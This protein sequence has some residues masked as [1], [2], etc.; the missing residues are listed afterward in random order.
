MRVPW[1]LVA[2][3][4]Y[5]DVAL[6]V[7]LKVAALAQRAEGCTAGTRTL[8]GYLGM[9]VSSVERGLAQLARPAADDG[10]VELSST[11]RSK[12][13]GDGDTAVRRLRQV[14]RAERFV[15]LPVAACEDLTPRQLRAY[16]VI[17]YAS[18]RH[19]P[20]AEAELAQFLRHA[21]GVR[22]G[23]PVTAAAA[24][25]VVDAL[26]SV[27]WVTV[28]R[29]AGGRGRHQFHPHDIPPDERTGLPHTAP[30]PGGSGGA[31]GAPVDIPAQVGG[32]G[33]A[34]P[35]RPAVGDGSGSAVCAGSLT[36][37][38][39]HLSCS[40]EDDRALY[41]PAVG[42]V[43]VREGV[44]N[45]PPPSAPRGSQD[46]FVPRA[47]H[48]PPPPSPGR[49]EGRYDGPVLTLSPR[50]YH[51]LEPVHWLLKQATSWE[52][53]C[54]AR[55]VGRQLRAGTEAARLSDRL[56]R[57]FASIVAADIR[58]PGRW[59]L[60]V[61]LPRWGCAQ[62]ECE[63]GMLW[64]SGACCEECRASLAAR[65]RA[66]RLAHGVR[67]EHTG[68]PSPGGVCPDCEAGRA[69]GAPPPVTERPAKRVHA[70]CMT[71]RHPVVLDPA[72]PGDRV[73]V[74]CRD[75]SHL[76]SAPPRTGLPVSCQGF[77]GKLCERTALLG[78]TRC[79]RCLARSEMTVAAPAAS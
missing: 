79:L 76:A 24:G 64:A 33:S 51:V 6:A 70:W 69:A 25:R 48:H 74:A 13:G 39:D 45:S 55:E 50:I 61:A 31:V 10:V 19:I 9:S 78:K 15:W 46:R 41:A 71:C 4:G 8:A 65:R 34:S 72:A 57:R 2:S 54:I 12:P 21:R 77:G 73:C 66:E 5:E 58:S 40:P 62:A 35:E 59:L 60:G 67:A 75:Q 42:E 47:D 36:Y 30:V 63:E 49:F 11:R 22:A 44:E 17:V 37:R 14:G 3:A 28:E 29:R 1:R 56:R 7:Y 43:Q 32:S 27:G 23:C 20:L 18:A 52:Q 26:E 53:R 16:A 68:T 38:E